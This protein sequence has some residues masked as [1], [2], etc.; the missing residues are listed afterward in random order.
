MGSIGYFEAATEALGKLEGRIEAI[1]ECAQEWTSRDVKCDLQETQDAQLSTV[2]EELAQ[3]RQLLATQDNQLAALRMFRAASQPIMDEHQKQFN[4]LRDEVMSTQAVLGNQEKEIDN[5]KTEFSRAQDQ[6]RAQ[7]EEIATLNT[8]LAAATSAIATLTTASTSKDDHLATHNQVLKNLARDVDELAVRTVRTTPCTFG[9]SP[10]LLPLLPMPDIAADYGA[11][12]SRVFCLN[13]PEHFSPP[14]DIDPTKR[15]EITCDVRCPFSS[16]TF[17]NDS[18]ESY[19]YLAVK[20]LDARLHP[21]APVD[22]LRKGA[23]CTVLAFDEANNTLTLDRD[24]SSEWFASGPCHQRSLGIYADG[25]T[26]RVRP[27]KVLQNTSCAWNSKRPSDGA[28]SRI[29]GQVMYLNMDVPSS[30][31]VRPQVSKVWNHYGGG[32]YMYPADQGCYVEAKSMGGK[33]HVL[34]GCVGK[35]MKTWGRDDTRFW[36]GTRFLQVGVVVS[37]AEDSKHTPL[38]TLVRRIHVR[39]I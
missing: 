4:V 9:A 21:I 22:V 1:E 18:P 37:T 11:E 34:R 33:W 3:M 38:P 23:P 10:E 12:N 28:Y 32:K 31:N 27:D 13:K 5:L 29:T 17:P 24:V 36:K 15:Y 25:V 26:D 30:I 19:I 20:C 6:I 14:I 16:D 39:E 35:E 8:G 2:T 7:Q